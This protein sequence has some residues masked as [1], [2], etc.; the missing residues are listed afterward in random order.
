MGLLPQDGWHFPSAF[1]CP[2]LVPDQAQ[3]PPFGGH[4]RGVPGWPQGGVVGGQAAW[5]EK[6]GVE[7][8]GPL[9]FLVWFSLQEQNC[10][11]PHSGQ[12]I[13]PGVS[14]VYASAA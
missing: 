3:W 12:L 10:I 1:S 5:S 11:W 4:C 14:F 9:P 13:R 2:G 8:G 6:G 7:G